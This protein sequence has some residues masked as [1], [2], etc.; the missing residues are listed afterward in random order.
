[1]NR[2][3]SSGPSVH[4]RVTG[5][6]I[7]NDGTHR[8]GVAFP[9]FPLGPLRTARYMMIN[10]HFQVMPSNVQSLPQQNNSYVLMSFARTSGCVLYLTFQGHIGIRCYRTG[11]ELVSGQVLTWPTGT[12]SLLDGRPHKVSLLYSTRGGDEIRVT[13]D[14]MVVLSLTAPLSTAIGSISR[15]INFF[16]DP[17]FWQYGRLP[18]A[19]SRVSILGSDSLSSLTSQ[20]TNLLFNVQPM[21]G[22][23]SNLARVAGLSTKWT[24]CVFARRVGVPVVYESMT[25]RLTAVD[26][27]NNVV[28]VP[29]DVFSLGCSRP[30][31]EIFFPAGQSSVANQF[32][33]VYKP[34]FPTTFTSEDVG[35]PALWM[36]MAFV[37]DG[38]KQITVG[39]GIR[40]ARSG[41]AR[42]EVAVEYA[43]TARYVAVQSCCGT[44]ANR[45]CNRDDDLQNDTF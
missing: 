17:Y 35:D 8:N 19:L 25:C 26:A 43:D 10:F 34:S 1:M 40:Y 42:L 38:F 45:V 30:M 21:P 13:V 3:F 2:Y 28:T 11:V 41:S 12:F 6:L 29:M 37:T 22:S 31:C 24:R 16:N 18:A 32:T 5:A 36:D 9:L 39:F 15:S 23:L 7:A 4:M 20:A 33:F 44:I 27:S 14:G